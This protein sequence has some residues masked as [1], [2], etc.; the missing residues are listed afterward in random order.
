MWWLHWDKL[1]GACYKPNK[2]IY[3]F[4]SEAQLLYEQVYFIT[5]DVREQK[6]AVT[7]CDFY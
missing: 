4:Q 1:I 6:L 5:I 3:F 2:T 7:C